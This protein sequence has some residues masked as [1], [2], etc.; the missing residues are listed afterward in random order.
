MM[1]DRFNLDSHKFY[2]HPDAISDFIQN[3]P[4]KP[5]Y[6]EISP[7][8]FCNHHCVFCHY[9]YL[10][11]HGRFEDNNRL[12]SLIDEIKKVGAKSLVFA[13]IGEPLL[14]K[15][16]IPSIVY[17]K[18]IGLDIGLSTNGALL[19]EEDFEPLARALTWVRFS[20]NATDEQTYQRI[21]QAKSGDF[22]RVLTN[23]EKL[24]AAK[25]R[26]DASI[27]IGVQF[28]LL[29][30]NYQ[31]LEAL[32]IR[33]KKIGIDYFVIKQFYKHSKNPFQLDGIFPNEDVMK[34][35]ME[36]S[37]KYNDV[38]FNFIVRSPQVLEEDRK[39]TQCYGLP[40]ILYIREDGN[41]FT[42]FSFQH[43]EKTILG[44][45]FEN[46]LDTIW[47]SS[48]KEDALC[49]INTMIDKTKCQ[50]SCRHHH[51]NNY[52]WELKHPSPHINFI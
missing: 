50:P 35:L 42:C 20:F 37:F 36:L 11:H 3:K 32:V 27:T 47:E 29:P 6:V 33:L 26:V 30:D 34:S 16:T 5:I 43:D 12:V 10:G 4:A 28:I 18:S 15:H 45:I 38:N 17:A 13:G 7:T 44:N 52:L 49:Y 25:K 21:H 19:K 24:V 9:N 31:H 2:Y 41:V 51:I 39:Y 48:K 14:N 40:Y 22:E 23:I 8:A 1:K 46:S